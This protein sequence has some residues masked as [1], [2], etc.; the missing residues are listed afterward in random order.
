MLKTISHQQTINQFQIFTSQPTSIMS[1]VHK[2]IIW[3]ITLLPLMIYIYYN[4]V[5][6]YTV[7]WDE[8]C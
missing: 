3:Y 2:Y 7:L 8:E 4:Y 6:D 5:M 1:Y